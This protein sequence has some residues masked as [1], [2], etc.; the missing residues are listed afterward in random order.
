MS[1]EVDIAKT[2][3]ELCALTLET[4]DGLRT[5][6]DALNRGVPAV[7]LQRQWELM[8]IDLVFGVSG[9]LARAAAYEGALRMSRASDAADEE[10]ECR[11]FVCDRKSAAAGALLE[12]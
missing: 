9:S 11:L 8:R 6:A 2:R 4:A 10:A 3:A 1:L 5:L 7:E 12:R